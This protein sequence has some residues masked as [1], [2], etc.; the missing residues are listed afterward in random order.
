MIAE[1]TT[2]RPVQSILD[3]L[4]AR[5]RVVQLINY[6]FPASTAIEF[7][8]P[9]D[10]FTFERDG[11]TLS[12]RFQ[13]PISNHP[14]DKVPWFLKFLLDFYFF[15]SGNGILV[16][17]DDCVRNRLLHLYLR[18]SGQK[19][20]PNCY[21]PHARGFP[22][23]TVFVRSNVADIDPVERVCSRFKLFNFRR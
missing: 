20:L 8:L 9:R 19:T 2:L 6:V 22:S 11:K 10:A 12:N 5:T 1:K 13:H 21:Q 16:R 14:P 15:H 17:N 18:Q 4:T 3:Y 7:N 23:W